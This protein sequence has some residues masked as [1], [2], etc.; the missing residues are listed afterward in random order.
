[1]QTIVFYL[2]PGTYNIFSA[3][4]V[5]AYFNYLNNLTIQFTNTA[6]IEISKTQKVVSV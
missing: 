1:M 3:L 2:Y 6:Q 4:V 5:I